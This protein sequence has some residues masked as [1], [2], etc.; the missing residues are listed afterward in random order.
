MAWA[1][2]SK[3]H[4]V[5]I[6]PTPE[7]YARCDIDAAQLLA[8]VDDAECPDDDSLGPSARR[9]S[10]RDRS[11]M[12]GRGVVDCVLGQCFWIL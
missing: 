7:A 3:H 4:N 9:G 12:R 1:R 5:Y 11:Q 8:S 2:Y 6:V 10:R